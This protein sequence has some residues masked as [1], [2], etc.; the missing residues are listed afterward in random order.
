MECRLNVDDREVVFTSK[1][2]RIRE[3]NDCNKPCVLILCEENQNEDTFAAK[4]AVSGDDM[5]FCKCIEARADSTDNNNNIQDYSDIHDAGGAPDMNDI[6]EDNLEFVRRVIARCDGTPLCVYETSRLLIRELCAKD[7]AQVAKIYADGEGYIEPFWDAG[8]HSGAKGRVLNAGGIIG[9]ELNKAHEIRNVQ[10]EIASYLKSYADH[11]YDVKGYG[12]WGVCLKDE[13]GLHNA[14]HNAMPAASSEI[15]GI[16]G[17]S[18]NFTVEAPSRDI[19]SSCGIGTPCDIDSS[20]GTDTSCNTDSSLDANCLYYKDMLELGFA[21]IKEARGFGYAFEACEGALKYANEKLN[22]QR[23][24]MRTDKTNT[25]AIKL[26]RK[27][28]IDYIISSK[29]F[30]EI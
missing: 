20:C 5:W 10:D 8:E 18:D 25:S 28:G 22:G 1:M 30:C 21:F 6:S 26:G 11:V 15:V 14:K 2:S 29:H 27:L 7:A 19:D 13:N 12:M 23:V 9:D 4:F 17:F 3:L 16:V 24:F